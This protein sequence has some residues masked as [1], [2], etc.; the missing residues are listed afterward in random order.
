MS[1]ES[2][3]RRIR[4]ILPGGA[5]LDAARRPALVLAYVGDTVYDL[6]VRTWLVS[7]HDATAHTLH[8]LASKR[9][10]AKAQAEALR[11][12]TPHLSE[13]EASVCRRGRNAKVGTVPKN[14]E[15]SDYLAATGLEALLGY[16]FL[17]GQDERLMQVMRCTL[18]PDAAL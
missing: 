9:V 14:A 8:T 12:L 1:E 4:S 6:F 5:E 7:R 10:C 13:T 18:E 11:R 17:S 16:L 3:C 2:I 15:L